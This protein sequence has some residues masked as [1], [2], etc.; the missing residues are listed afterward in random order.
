[1]NNPAPPASHDFTSARTR[2]AVLSML[3]P[4]A[5]VAQAQ[6]VRVH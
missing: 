4:L 2:I 1:M 3:A 6:D 5:L